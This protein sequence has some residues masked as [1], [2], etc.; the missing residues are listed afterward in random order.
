MKTKSLVFALAFIS[1]LVGC[2]PA[3]SAIPPQPIYQYK[4]EIID[5][6]KT[7]QPSSEKQYFILLHY[8]DITKGSKPL[9]GNPITDSTSP[10]SFKTIDGV[11]ETLDCVHTALSKNLGEQVA[12]G[13]ELMS[14]QPLGTNPYDFNI[15][16]TF[17]TI[18]R[19]EK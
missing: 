9:T 3:Q 11:R 17:M 5:T 8:Y 4:H 2:V 13:W 19:K 16:Y 1:I 7:C 12:S 6:S 18:W 10:E 15:E 14:I